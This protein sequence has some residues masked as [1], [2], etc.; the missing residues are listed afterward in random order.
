MRM[1]L[2]ELVAA[3][4]FGIACAIGL[5]G[6]FVGLQTSS[7][8]S[9]ELFTAWVVGVDNNAAQVLHRALTDLHPPLYYCLAFLFSQ[10]AGHS[11]VALRLPSAL[12]ACAAIILFVTTTSSAFS[13]TGRLFGAAMATG[14]VFWSYQAQNARDYA[15]SLAI[16]TVLLAL[17]LQIL[18]DARAGKGPSARLVWSLF[19]VMF[20]CAFVHFYLLFECL[21]VLMVLALYA[22]GRRLLFIGAFIALLALGGLY[23]KLV[24][25]RYTEY[26]LAHN[27]IASNPGWYIFEFK[28]AVQATV[29]PFALAALAVCGAAWMF[30]VLRRPV[31]ATAES[32]ASA[33]GPDAMTRDRF[34]GLDPRF[35]LCV[36][37]PILVTC[38]GVVTSIVI[39]PNLTDRNILVCSPFIWG[40]FAQSYDAGVPT[41]RPALRRPASVVL[42]LLALLM[43]T[44]VVGRTLPQTEPYRESAR[45]IVRT[46]PRCAGQDIPIIDA[47][48]RA[49]GNPAWTQ[50]VLASEYGRYLSGFARPR[51]IYLEDITGNRLPDDFRTE[52]RKRIEGH[53]CEL[54]GW[55]VHISSAEQLRSMTQGLQAAAGG[56]ATTSVIRTRTFSAFDFSPARI[57]AVQSGFVFYVD[58]RLERPQP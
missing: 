37:V 7:L 38:A 22:G 35:V 6:A 52:L 9:D 29:G 10:I 30:G 57:V 12:C 49:W 31:Q 11:D 26:S 47:D 21:A 19:A 50:T 4:A 23:T 20:V 34:S 2:D 56:T 36:A 55:Y 48:A 51:V 43:S 39:S 8:W 33:L 15:L 25:Q 32:G 14:S 16:G 44:I 1:R 58:D 3:G 45:W 17:S 46:F 18:S 5:V 54:L 13:L 24:I 27:W 40:L 28:R 53:G 42:A 41:L